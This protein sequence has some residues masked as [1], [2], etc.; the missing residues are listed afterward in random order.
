MTEQ[1]AWVG[2]VSN[3]DQYVHRCVTGI[4]NTNSETGI[5]NREQKGGITHREQEEKG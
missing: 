5:T 1:A 2:C 3:N 4:T